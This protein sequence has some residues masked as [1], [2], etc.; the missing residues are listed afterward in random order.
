M[1][2][3]HNGIKTENNL[4]QLLR[5]SDKDMLLAEYLMLKMPQ[6]EYE[7]KHYFS[8]GLYTRELFMPAGSFAIGME[9]VEQHVLNIIVK[10]SCTFLD[11]SNEIKTLKAPCVFVSET[12]KK[13]IGYFEEDTIWLNVHKTDKTDLE[14]VEKELFI[15][16]DFSVI[17]DQ[18]DYMNAVEE[19]GIPHTEVLDQVTETRDLV[20]IDM[21]LF[22]V[23]IKNSPIH[24]VGVF[25]TKDISAWE[26]IAPSKICGFRTA[27]GRYVNH[28]KDCNAEMQ[29]LDEESIHL[30]AIKDIK[31]G[32]EITTDYRNS[33][34]L[35]M[36]GDKCQQ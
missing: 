1:A 22:P 29:F 5:M 36:G 28:G 24:G 32:E 25:A 9:H 12:G 2:I 15:V 31:N 34:K 19:I 35:L 23:E 6:V 18:I 8:E 30:V 7:N 13:K 33:V 16:S 11:G 27:A 3:I 26:A 4:P 10:G 21:G 14:E 17:A 20:G